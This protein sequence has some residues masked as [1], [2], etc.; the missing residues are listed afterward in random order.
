MSITFSKNQIANFIYILI[1]ISGISMFSRG[2]FIDKPN[3]C[4]I[5]MY[6][7]FT[8]VV[9]AINWGKHLPAQAAALL[10][11][12]LCTIGAALLVKAMGYTFDS[13]DPF[14]IGLTLVIAGVNIIVASQIKKLG[15]NAF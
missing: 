4:C 2:V 11:V 10:V 15:L 1:G 7:T 5:G 9:I 3:L 14:A 13:F 6:I 8:I 12:M